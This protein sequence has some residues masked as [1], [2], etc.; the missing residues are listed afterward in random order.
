MSGNRSIKSISL[1]PLLFDLAAC[2]GLAL[3]FIL[4]PELSIR[5]YQRG[6]FCNDESLRLPYKDDTIPPGLLVVILLIIGVGI[7]ASTEVYRDFRLRNLDSPNYVLHGV[8][9]NRVTDRAVLSGYCMIGMCFEYVTC[10]ATK[11]AVGRLRPHFIDVCKPNIGYLTCNNPYVYITNYT[12]TSSFSEYLKKEAHVSFYSGHTAT[13]MHV[14]A[15]CVIYLYVRLPRRIY[16]VTLVPIIQTILTTAG[17]LV[18]YSRISDHKHHW[19]DVFAGVVVGVIT[20]SFSVS[21]FGFKALLNFQAIFLARLFKRQKFLLS[22]SQELLIVDYNDTEDFV[23]E[24]RTRINTPSETAQSNAFQDSQQSRSQLPSTADAQVR[25]SSTGF[26]SHHNTAY[27]GD[28]VF[29]PPNESNSQFVTKIST[30]FAPFDE[31]YSKTH[32]IAIT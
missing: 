2:F 16:G 28:R 18:G 32:Q 9:I 31:N 5:P 15:Y 22:K 10:E 13:T 4:V 1:G 17:I 29:V 6:F 24:N 27:E 20:G 14:V 21:I 26:A 30:S 3:L 23:P 11:L 7:I 19:S 12:C 8:D 25:F